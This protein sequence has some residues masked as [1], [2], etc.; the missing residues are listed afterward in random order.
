[1]VNNSITYFLRK[2]A[3]FWDAL[4]VF[5]RKRKSTERPCWDVG[6]QKCLEARITVDA[7]SIQGTGGQLRL[8]ACGVD[9]TAHARFAIVADGEQQLP[10][11]LTEVGR[12]MHSS[13]GFWL[14]AMHLPGGPG[15][16]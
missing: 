6:T 16:M 4:E 2:S 15:A 1:M 14:I 10:V 12:S 9:Q 7:E 3:C 11:V 8:L 13:G 5:A